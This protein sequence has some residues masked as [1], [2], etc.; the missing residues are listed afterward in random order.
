MRNNRF[1]PWIMAV[2][3]S[4]SISSVH[5]AGALADPSM[6]SGAANAPS[7]ASSG[8]AVPSAPQTKA[9]RQQLRDTLKRIQAHYKGTNSFSAKFTEQIFAVGGGKRD[10]SGK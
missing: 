3:L 7:G 8:P 9:E 1:L 2:L 5:R 10:R 6:T 4:L